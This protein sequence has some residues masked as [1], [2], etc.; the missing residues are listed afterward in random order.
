MP[1][2]SGQIEWVDSLQY[3]GV[4]LTGGCSL[5]FKCAS[6]KQSFIAACNCIYAHAKHLDEIVHLT[7]PESYG[8][9]IL[10]YDVAVAKYTVTQ[11]DVYRK[12]FGFNKW[13]S[14]KRIRCYVD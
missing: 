6:L 1:L 2:G 9:S 5:G 11:E 12:I 13:E 8:L 7:L 4:T 10:T 3:L 14:V